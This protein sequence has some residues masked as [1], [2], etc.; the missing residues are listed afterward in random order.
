MRYPPRDYVP[1][2]PLKYGWYPKSSQYRTHYLTRWLIAT[3]FTYTTNQTLPTA[4]NG[5]FA[6]A[7][8]VVDQG[9]VCALAT[10]LELMFLSAN[11]VL[12]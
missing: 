3:L 4:L 2:A 12:N 8:V 6:S 9:L 10:Y 1:A 11:S 7:M 5:L